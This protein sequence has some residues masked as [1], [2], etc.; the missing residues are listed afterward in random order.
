M[1]KRPMALMGLARAIALALGTVGTGL[2]AAHAQTGTDNAPQRL[3]LEQLLR[4]VPA[5]FVDRLGSESAVPGAM[6][7]RVSCQELTPAVLNRLTLL[8]AVA[9]VLCKTP[10]LN[11]AL[12]LVDEQQ[13]ASDVARAAF[14]P[15]LSARAELS[16]R[17]IP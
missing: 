2:T 10:A 8:D 6:P 15:R 11:Q 14:R 9:Y 16:A 5:V 1:K 7:E 4:S 12:L 3:R 17:G 13:A